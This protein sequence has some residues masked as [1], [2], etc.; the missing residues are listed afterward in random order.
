M[1]ENQ[2]VVPIGEPCPS[3]GGALPDYY[4]IAR[5]TESYFDRF[6]DSP[7]GM[8]WTTQ[9]GARARYRVML[10]VIQPQSPR[11]VRLLDVG[12]GG[13]YLLEYIR[14]TCPYDIEYSGIDISPRFVD[15]CRRKFPR[16]SFELLDVLENPGEL[17]EFDYIVINGV[18]TSKCSMTF[19]Q[20]W[21]FARRLLAALFPRARYG[22]AFNATSKQVDWERDD[23]FHLPLDTVADFLCRNLTRNF[24]IRNDYGQYEFTTYVYK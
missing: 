8:G 1:R 10:E 2:S 14:S 20:M 11:P 9:A 3:H 23:L 12:C 18:F 17:S 4:E 24:L 19:E 6:G 16:H 5:C 7:L 22:L 13:G 21:E 15:L